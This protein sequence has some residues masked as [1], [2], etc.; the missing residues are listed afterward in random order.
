MIIGRNE[1]IGKI[2][3]RG[4]IS[5]SQVV[6]LDMDLAVAYDPHQIDIEV[7]QPLGNVL[8]GRLNK[9]LL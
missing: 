6:E 7:Q 4:F 5:S 9:N 2:R 8:V 1:R 3:D